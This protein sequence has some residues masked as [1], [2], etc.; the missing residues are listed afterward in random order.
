MWLM[1][2]VTHAR[3]MTIY[4][5]DQPVFVHDC[6]QF[7]P[8]STLMIVLNSAQQVASALINATAVIISNDTVFNVI[9]PANSS[10]P[11]G[12]SYELPVIDAGSIDGNLQHLQVTHQDHQKCQATASAR[13]SQVSNLQVILTIDFDDSCPGL[14]RR[15]IAAIVVGSIV[16]GALIVGVLMFVVLKKRR[17]FCLFNW[18]HTNARSSFIN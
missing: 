9:I 6:L 4:A 11:A 12:S 16:G 2:Y 15:V 10:Y 18:R 14:S 1:P 13:Q 3:E 8:G 7:L 5:T 17:S